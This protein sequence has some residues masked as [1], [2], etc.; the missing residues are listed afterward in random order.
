MSQLAQ[1]FALKRALEDHDFCVA[2]TAFFADQLDNARIRAV[3]ALNENPC[4]IE[5]AIKWSAKAEVAQE[6]FNQLE[7]FTRQQLSRT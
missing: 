6:A 2:L 3:A 5:N 1:A 4:A 7:E